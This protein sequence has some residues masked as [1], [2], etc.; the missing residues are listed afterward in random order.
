MYMYAVEADEDDDDMISSVRLHC[1]LCI[2]KGLFRTLVSLSH[3]SNC[4]SSEKLNCS[5]CRR[6][7]SMYAT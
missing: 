6:L 1:A 5:V 3:C 2:R 7:L 4:V